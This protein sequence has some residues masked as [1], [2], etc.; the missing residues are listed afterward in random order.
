MISFFHCYWER[1]S[2][3]TWHILQFSV[4]H[5]Y[6][7]S[8]S[9]QVNP[10]HQWNFSER[11]WLGE[12]WIRPSTRV[13]YAV[14][15]WRHPLVEKHK[16]STRASYALSDD[17]RHLRITQHHASY[18]PATINRSNIQQTDKEARPRESRPFQWWHGVEWT[19]NCH[20]WLADSSFKRSI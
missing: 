10:A 6:D 4:G 13:L 15:Q 2:K 12:L 5:V 18:W 8:V 19:Q 1:A 14:V 16:Q 3:L 17:R 20:H 9:V 7:W 11:G